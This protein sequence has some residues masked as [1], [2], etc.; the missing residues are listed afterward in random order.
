MTESVIVHVE[1][2]EKHILA[3][4]GKEKCITQEFFDILKKRN[5]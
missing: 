4:D 5:E 2:H 1:K 3:L